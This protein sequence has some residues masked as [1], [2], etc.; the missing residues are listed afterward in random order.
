MEDFPEDVRT[1]QEFGHRSL[2][3]KPHPFTPVQLTVIENT[4]K[5]LL[6]QAL[7]SHPFSPP[8][9]FLGASFPL[10]GTQPR[11]PGTASSLGLHRPLD[12]SLKDKILRGEYIDLTILLPDSLTRPQV[13]NLQFRLEDSTPG[14][15]SS[16][17]TI[18]SIHTSHNASRFGG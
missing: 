11:R 5:V 18:L 8:Q 10:S 6:S 3:F 12:R 17:V 14:S 2:A 13:P 7:Q 15:P 9:S 1:L 4:V 16:A